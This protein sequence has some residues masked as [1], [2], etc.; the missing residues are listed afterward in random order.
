MKKGDEVIAKESI[1][2][3]KPDPSADPYEDGWVFASKNS[4]GMIA[5]K[6]DNGKYTVYFFDSQTATVISESKIEVINAT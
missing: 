4:K 6:E 5:S 1:S 2:I 3:G